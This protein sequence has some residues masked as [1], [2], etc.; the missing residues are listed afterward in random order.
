MPILAATYPRPLSLRPI[1]LVC[2]ALSVVLTCVLANLPFVVIAVAVMTTLILLVG[3]K[4]LGALFLGG[5]C[6]HATF[7]YLSLTT[8]GVIGG[9]VDSNISAFALD[10]YK[11]YFF[12]I[13]AML[14][15][16]GATSERKFDGPAIALRLQRMDRLTLWFA[17]AGGLL[18]AYVLHQIGF[19]QMIL[20]GTFSRYFGEEQT[21]SSYMLYQSLL[22]RGLAALMV[23][24]P[25]ALLRWQQTRSKRL[26]MAA[27]VGILLM[28]CTTRRGYL[29]IAI[30]SFVITNAIMGRHRKLI[31]VTILG[32]AIAF[33]SLQAVFVSIQSDTNSLLANTA[34]VLRSASTEVNDLAW[35]LSEFNG[36]WYLGATWLAALWPL[37]ATLSTFKD[38]YN[39]ASVTKDVAGIPRDAE[40]GGL[41]ISMFGEAFLNFGYFGVVGLGLI[42]GVFVRKIN[43]LLAWAKF[44]GPLILFPCVFLY[45]VAVCQFYLSGT[46]VLSDAI[47]SCLVLAAIY[48]LS[49]QRKERPVAQ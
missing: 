6:V 27:A 14:V 23:T 46:G 5:T 49:M 21:G 36:H 15:A 44:R 26:L 18:L 29:A 25:I 2:L 35:V 19:V 30:L 48:W 28:L 45:L 24:I 20:S 8:V 47:L 42:F 16:Y 43:A 12:G 4:S 11:V 39:L 41:R 22:R 10:A 37:P 1:L 17:I 3:D 7:S 38:S 13:V 32:L 34:F 33:F 40:T 31:L 9:N